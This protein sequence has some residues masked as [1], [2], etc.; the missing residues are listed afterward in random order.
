MARNKRGSNRQN[1]RPSERISDDQNFAQAVKTLFRIIQ[2]IHHFAI[3]NNQLNGIV[4]K[5]FEAKLADLNKFVKPAYPSAQAQQIDL[6]NNRWLQDITESL[7]AHFRES[8]DNIKRQLST[9]RLE[10]SDCE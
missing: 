3:A 2:R 7:V 5:S 8:N 9:F 1:P 10:L 4:T 6:I